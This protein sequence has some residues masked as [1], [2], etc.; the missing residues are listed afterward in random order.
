MALEF[1]ID[2][3]A[4][5]KKRGWSTTKIRESTLIGQKTLADI[6]NGIVPGTIALNSLCYML[7]LQPG[8][9]VRY[10]PGDEIKKDKTR[11][12]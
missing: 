1:K 5:L 10:V 9:I 12:E 11:T 6:K 4:E 7:N 8:S 2:V 3:M